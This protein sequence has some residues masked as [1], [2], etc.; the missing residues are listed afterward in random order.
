VVAECYAEAL[1][2]LERG[3][4]LA[5]RLPTFGARRQALDGLRTNALRARSVGD[6]HA[7][8]NL[9]RFR[10][11]ITP[12]EPAE[13]E[14]L[15]R[16]GRAIWDSR[17]RILRPTSADRAA[18]AQ[19]RSDLI[20][21]ATILADL[22][23]HRGADAAAGSDRALA[24]Q[25][26]RTAE[27]E[28]GSTAALGRDLQRHA[29]DASTLDP[30]P[31]PLAPPHTA[32]EHYDL[33]RSYL[34]SG[35]HAQALAEFERAIEMRP[36]EFWPHFYHGICAYKLDR[37]GDAVSSLSTAIALA[38]RTA[39][40][41]YNRA[42]AY[43]ALGRRE[44]ALRDDTRALE[45]DPRFTDAALNR[46]VLHFRAGRHT[47]ALADLARARATAASASALGRIAYNEALVHRARKDW[48]AAHASVEEAIAQGDADARRLAAEL[49]AP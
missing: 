39:E 41:Y 15:Y 14:K 43:Q 4:A 21:L 10:F 20:D 22:C 44:E 12:P 38:P 47:A 5:G 18:E 23:V 8:M 37:H 48:R 25:I 9:Y 26:L 33:G 45:L 24:V 2:C 27:T 36:E 40:C 28:L 29:G 17:G 30:G 3:A 6:L 13:A 32:W 35:A 49:G 34:R 19:V 31:T 42:L 16:R 11:G 7:L 1:L 46:A